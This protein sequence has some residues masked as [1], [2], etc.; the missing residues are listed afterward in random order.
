MNIG[1]RSFL[2]FIIGGAAGT[3]LT[4]LPW[5]LT[6]DLSIWTQTW[7]WTPVPED[8]A[9]NYVNSVCTLC[10]GGC[11]ITVRKIDD[12]AVKIEGMAGYPV[13]YGGICVMGLSGL[14]LLYG[15]RRVKGPLKRVGARGEG[16]W[17]PITWDAAI[18]EVSGKL[19]DLR[20]AGKPDS[21]ACVLGSE[22]GT[23]PELFRRFMTSYGSANV[24]TP[25]TV[26]DSYGITMKLMQ[27]ARAIPGVDAENADFV[28]S[29]GAGVLDGW[30]SPVRM[31]QAHSH[32]R[33]N[34]GRLVQVE[35]RLSNTAAKA[36]KW[37][38]INP[39]TEAVLALGI[40]NVLITM[41]HYNKT[42]VEKYAFGFE[43][44]TDSDGNPAKGFKS[45]VLET[46][47]VEEVS[48]ITGVEVALIAEIAKNFGTAKRPLA[49]GGRGKGNSAA[50]VHELMAIHALNALAGNINRPGGI[51]AID[52]PDYVD[53]PD[54][55]TDEIARKGL[56]KGRL[57]G[58]GS[59]RYPHTRSIISRLPELMA[60]GE[61]PIEALLVSGANPLYTLADTQA[62]TAALEK[63]PFLVS[64]SEYM[65]ETAEM[66]DLILP[67][68]VYLERHEDV[69][70]PFGLHKPVIGMAR[71]VVKPVHN[72][73]HV[74]DTLIALGRRMGGPIADAMEWENY[75]ACLKGTMGGAWD[76]L[77]K[78]GFLC[79]P[80]FTPA[81]WN[82][83]FAGTTSKKFEFFNPSYRHQPETDILAQVRIAGDA[84]AF[85]L[86]LVPCDSMR[87]ATGPVADP[88]FMVKTVSDTV[89]T[90]DDLM[91]E[92]NPE[93]AH[94]VGLSEGR[95]A[96]LSTPDGEA[97]VRIHL[98]EGIAPGL[99]GIPTGLGH[100]GNSRYIANK[101]VNANRLIGPLADPI[102]GQNAAWGIRAKLARA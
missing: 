2:S 93:T 84:D 64:F 49:L 57:D 46:Y 76:G 58:A 22:Y 90:G 47:P 36:D 6:D 77:E 28:L 42:F 38:A 3:A 78:D 100:T 81:D 61:A 39:G 59:E 12:R 25:E 40:A 10:P 15:P 55:P 70:A 17:E 97:R 45:Y 86:L 11:G 63:I 66:A 52:P 62:V 94:A 54:P 99:V 67:N 102:S 29:F 23:V 88:P 34:G 1:R 18:A 5:K 68:H 16:R 32:W 41:G 50:S 56:A 30:G 80:Q 74:G 87:L 79:N 4:P 37:V 69:P 13:N 31:F 72:T 91:V 7:P 65:D 14:Q 101:G 89:L 60:D 43:D 24:F 48:R 33:D 82:K 83:A 95:K 51:W 98:Y 26:S 85:P 96:K 53:W 19:G 71:P 35:P 73:R 21:V 92:V 20:A 9:A 8:G 27:G 44:F 75:E